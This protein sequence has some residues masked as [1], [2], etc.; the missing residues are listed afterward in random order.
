MEYGD[1]IT[2]FN[3]LGGAIQIK[4]NINFEIIEKYKFNLLTNE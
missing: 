4:S 1:V 3:E 2:W